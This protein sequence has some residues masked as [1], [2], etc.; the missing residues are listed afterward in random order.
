MAN[1]PIRKA[2]ARI[3]SDPLYAKLAFFKHH[4]HFPRNPAV[5]F[6]E[7]IC[8]LIGSGR[9]EDFQPY[10]D[11]LK[12]RDYVARKIG[13]EYLVPL[14]A[15]AETLTADLWKS[16]PD[17][18]VLKPNHGS[19]WYRVVRNKSEWSLETV[20]ALAEDW[21]KKDFYFVRRERQ[22]RNLKRCLMFEKLLD[23]NISG[24][25]ADHR[26]FCFNGNPAFVQVTLREQNKR[27]I[28]YDL[29]WNKL[30]VEYKYPNSG[31]VSRPLNLEKMLEVAQC[32][33]EGFEFVR[34]DLHDTPQG[35]FF[36]ELTFMPNVGADRF[37]PEEFDEFLGT[38]WRA[39]SN[40]RLPDFSRWHIKSSPQ[41]ERALVQDIPI[42]PQSVRVAE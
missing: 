21:L 29:T 9:L 35:V 6:N 31:M 18:F 25:V 11:K 4:R 2:T 36:G 16:L 23:R 42:A 26:I 33:A 24:T 32:M 10:S 20:T 22:Y 17:S 40:G 7:Y 38:C 34:V 30:D 28:L 8:N 15:V 1:Y 5:T 19:G 39:S 3:I 41:R 14:Y 13:E 12:V 27:R 37:Y